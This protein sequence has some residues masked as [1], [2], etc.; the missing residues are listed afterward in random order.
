MSGIE[1]DDFDAPSSPTG[2]DNWDLHAIKSVDVEP[3]Q[4]PTPILNI[5]KWPSSDPEGPIGR[6][7]D[8]RELLSRGLGPRKWVI[9]DKLKPPPEIQNDSI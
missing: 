6:E 1:V 9:L 2:R 4:V 3:D 7:F 5:L 8:I